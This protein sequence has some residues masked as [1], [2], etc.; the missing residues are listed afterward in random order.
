MTVSGAPFGRGDEL[1]IIGPALGSL[2]S[3][4]EERRLTTEQRRHVSFVLELVDL[5]ASRHGF[6]ADELVNPRTGEPLGPL[7]DRLRSA[8]RGRGA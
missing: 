8:V 2:A 6:D 5:L 4:T 1:W 3:V 7:L